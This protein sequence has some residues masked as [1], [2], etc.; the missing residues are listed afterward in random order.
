[1]KIEGDSDNWLGGGRAKV[2]GEDD[3]GM[4]LDRLLE[5]SVTGAAGEC[6]LV[7]SIMPG[8]SS[9]R[10]RSTSVVFVSAII[11][12]SLSKETWFSRV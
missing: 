7:G 11:R 8:M 2:S 3:G 1:M 4:K 5:S 9:P 12:G 10:N 6:G